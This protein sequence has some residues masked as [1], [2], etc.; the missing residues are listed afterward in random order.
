MQP[1]EMREPQAWQPPNYGTGGH[2]AAQPQPQVP[3]QP[4]QEPRA[5][6]GPQGRH[7]PWSGM[8]GQ[9][10]GQPGAGAVPPA[11]AEPVVY[12]AKRRRR[13]LAWAV[14]LGS[15]IVLLGGGAVAG[16][17]VSRFVVTSKVQEYVRDALELGSQHEVEV[18]LG[19]LV[20]P[21]LL[22]GEVNGLDIEVS[23]VEVPGGPDITIE[24]SAASVPLDLEGG[25]LEGG[26]IALRIEGD[27]ID[28]FAHAALP[29]LRGVVDVSDGRLRVTH[30]TD[31]GADI[32][33][34]VELEPEGDRVE[35][36]FDGFAVRPTSAVRSGGE[37]R[38]IREF[39]GIDPAD[40]V[41]CVARFFPVGVELRDI[42]IERSG[43]V[44]LTAKIDPRIMRDSDLQE[45]G[46]CA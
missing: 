33:V 26:R 34:W 14:T 2:S 41:V 46:S 39:T 40:P 12:A 13:G 18:A 24:A 25:R 28:A 31:T 3:A 23:G 1:E 19:G 4:M 5:W 7:D 27:D 37:D 38:A 42:E 44:V 10:Y 22:V 20:L 36:A 32:E 6:A 21:G 29:E 43:E 8:R 30:T 45:L 9:P 15:L 11:Y 16:E 17:L 35:V